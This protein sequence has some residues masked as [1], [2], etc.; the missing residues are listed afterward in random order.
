MP[1]KKNKVVRYIGSASSQRG[2]IKYW[3][4]DNWISLPIDLPG[5]VLTTHGPGFLLSWEPLVCQSSSSSESSSSESS[6]SGLSSSSEASSS[7]SQL[8]SSGS[9]PSSSGSQPSSSGSQPSSSGSQPSS[10]G[11]QPSS[12]AIQSSSSSSNPEIGIAFSPPSETTG[13]RPKTTGS[14]DVHTTMGGTVDVVTTTHDRRGNPY[15]NIPYPFNASWNWD[16]NSSVN[17][18]II[19]GMQDPISNKET[20]ITYTQKSGFFPAVAIG[21]VHVKSDD[22]SASSSSTSR[23]GNIS[24]ASSSPNTTTYYGN[25]YIN[26]IFASPSDTSLTVN[27][28]YW[29]GSSIQAVSNTVTWSGINP[30]IIVINL[31]NIFFEVI[32]ERRNT[33]VFWKIKI[34]PATGTY[35]HNSIVNQNGKIG[36]MWFDSLKECKNYSDTN[37]I[38]DTNGHPLLLALGYSAAESTVGTY[39]WYGYEDT[40][41]A[42]PHFIPINRVSN[43]G[44]I[45][46]ASGFI[47]VARNTYEGTVNNVGNVLNNIDLKTIDAM[48]VI[49][50]DIDSHTGFWFVRNWWDG[51]IKAEGGTEDF[52]PCE[53]FWPAIDISISFPSSSASYGDVTWCGQTWAQAESGDTRKIC[54]SNY[55][56]EEPS[57][58]TSTVY[59]TFAIYTYIHYSAA[60]FWFF[61][62]GVYPA[63][64]LGMERLYRVSNYPIGT[65]LRFLRPF[66]FAL[67]AGV[68]NRLIVDN[69]HMDWKEWSG[70]GNP[71]LP[72]T[73]QASNTKYGDINKI[74]G[75]GKPT[76]NGDFELGNNF[77]GTY[78]D[79][80]SITYSWNQSTDGSWSNLKELQRA[81]DGV[82]ASFPH[83]EP[84]SPLA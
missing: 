54:P 7:G 69:T 23:T 19:F 82:L 48:A 57:Q 50:N 62:G 49:W 44:S 17:E 63:D 37:G 33:Y 56:Y 51:A 73:P 52:Y 79:S 32:G 59:G 25:G 12:S 72:W 68:R 2:D 28:E 26:L 70:Y 8:S 18:V 71:P 47:G 74:L 1:S 46:I 55:Q 36:G 21:S 29:N 34:A 60:N 11:A 81:R 77:F 30:P 5:E 45:N 40:E 31:D 20:A 78:T 14:G 15:S 41:S 83:G 16:D 9:Q 80:N 53:N 4:G 43:S 76:F 75:V 24:V 35:W 38:V 58:W 67:G 6:S 65:F 64:Q 39:G 42:S 84:V 27:G 61:G 22:W 3:D 66:I 13:P 10:S